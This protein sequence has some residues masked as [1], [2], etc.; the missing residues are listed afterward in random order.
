M[1]KNGIS[2]LGLS[3]LFLCLFGCGL[4]TVTYLYPPIDMTV[5]DTIVSV[6]NDAR[7]YEASEGSSQTFRGLEI[8]YRV[9]QN[10]ASAAASLATLNSLADTYSSDPE[11]FIAAAT[12]DTYK[13]LRLRSSATKGAPLLS[14][15]ASDSS[16]YYLNL[17]LD[18]D[19]TLSNGLTIIRNLDTS[20]SYTSFYLKDFVSGDDD[21][22]GSTILSTDTVYIVFFS[23][24]YGVDQTT[25][26]ETVYSL[27]TI[28]SNYASY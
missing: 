5:N 21:F 19:W 27:P 18:S 24:S 26:G 8:F 17:N 1:G 22:N 11:S 7:N 28:P 20:T 12:N 6:Q 4:P 10:E 23:V 16:D 13:F 2:L 25:V 3:V 14:I 9:Y 15:D